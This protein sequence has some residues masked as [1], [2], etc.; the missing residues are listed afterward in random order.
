MPR[1]LTRQY[2]MRAL[3]AVAFFLSSLIMAPCA[4]ANEE[5]GDTLIFQTLFEKWTDAFNRKDLGGSCSL[6]SNTV[7]ASYRGQPEKNFD[8]ICNGFKKIFAETKRSYRYRFKVHHVYR[9]GNLAAVRITWYLTVV[10]DGKLKSLTEDQGMDIL[11]KNESG[12]WQIVNYV[13][14]DE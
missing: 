5:Q 1:H 10:E 4:L 12:N 6:F 9:S 8:S 11:E 3:A 7:A 14:Y 13:A 2:P